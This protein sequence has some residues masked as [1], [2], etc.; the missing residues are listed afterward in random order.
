MN[1]ANQSLLTLIK[2]IRDTCDIKKVYIAKIEYEDGVWGLTEELEKIGIPVELLQMKPYL[3]FSGL[4]NLLALPLR[5]VINISTWFHIYEQLKNEDIDCVYSNTSVEN[6]GI[7]I[8][9]LL[10][11]KHIWHV[12]EFGYRDYK[13]SHLG[14]DFFKRKV[15]SRSDR[16]I[17]ISKSIADY[18]ALPKKTELIPNGIFYEKQLKG[19]APRSTLPAEVQI[20]MVGILGSTKNQKR[21][22]ELLKSISGSTPV[23]VHLNF[24]GGIGEAHY[25]QGMKNMILENNLE[26]NVTF[27][28]F[29]DNHH[30]IYRNMDILLMCSLN[31]AFGRV[32]VEA[33]ARGIPV[34]GYDNAGT[35]ELIT[36]GQNGLLYDDIGKTLEDVVE[37]LLHSR[38]L[39][40]E[41]SKKSHQ[42]AKRYSVER[43]GN[44][45]L[46][47]IN[48]L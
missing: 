34:V 27:H 25:V 29:V 44:S 38:E 48:E 22:L 10:G 4:K 32:T 6:T 13:Y 11:T 31:E 28:G 1:G 2:Y 3:Y 43:Y 37:S 9:K 18:I 15:L 30:E 36:D 40:T 24:Y 12:R 33:M 23:Q 8:A 35:G 21:A 26:D 39:Y 5:F 19:F 14:G 17:A 20:G 7:L 42:S 16:L 46:S 47:L 41:I 45:I